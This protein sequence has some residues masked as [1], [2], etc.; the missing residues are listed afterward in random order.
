ME[1]ISVIIEILACVI[2]FIICAAVV[3]TQF[4]N[5]ERVFGVKT[6]QLS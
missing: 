6:G 2:S 5:V 4:Q 3:N 1:W